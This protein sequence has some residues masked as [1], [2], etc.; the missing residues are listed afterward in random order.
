[1]EP[2]SYPCFHK[3]GSSGFNDVKAGRN[4][5]SALCLGSDGFPAVEGWDA[6]TGFGTPNFEKLSKLI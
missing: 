5:G 4:C 3:V 2:S 1:M 6:A